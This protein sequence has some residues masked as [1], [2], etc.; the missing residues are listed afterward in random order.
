MASGL[1]VSWTVAKY[2]VLVSLHLAPSIGQLSVPPLQLQFE[3]RGSCCSNLLSSLSTLLLLA[4][5][6][7]ERLG[8][9]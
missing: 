9:V 5:M 7:L 3:F 1:L 4:A 8:I 2:K 6:I